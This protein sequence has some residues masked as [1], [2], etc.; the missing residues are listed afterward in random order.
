M[1]AAYALTIHT[2]TTARLVA[3][4]GIAARTF[5]RR[6]FAFCALILRLRKRLLKESDRRK[7]FREE[8]RRRESVA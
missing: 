5:N 3:V 4:F 7:A 2:N 8:R 6:A 1:I